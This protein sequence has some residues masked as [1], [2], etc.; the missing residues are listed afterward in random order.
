MKLAVFV[1]YFPPHM[2]SD[3]RIYQIS[4]GLIKEFNLFFAVF[5]PLRA[6]GNITDNSLKSY[7]ENRERIKLPENF[8]A[9]YLNLSNVLYRLWNRFELVAYFIT[10]AI[11]FVR[12]IGLLKSI[13]PNLVVVAH[14]SYHCGLIGTVVAKI[15]NIP[16]VLDYPDLWTSMTLETLSLQQNGLKSV[17]LEAIESIPIYLANHIIVVTNTIRDKVLRKGINKSK[18]TIIPNGVSIDEISVCSNFEK[19]TIEDSD[20]KMILFSGRLERWAGLDCLINAIPSVL[21]TVP[22]SLFVI[23]GDGSY[24][25]FLEGK[26]ASA[27]FQENVIFTGFLQREKIWNLINKAN[28]CISIFSEGDTGTAAI[29]IK[30]LEYMALGKPIVTTDCKGLNKFLKDKETVLLAKND[31]TALASA[32]TNLLQNPSLACSL[33][34]CAKKIVLESFDWRLLSND[35]AQVCH[36]VLSSNLNPN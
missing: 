2:G 11:L 15:L 16:I 31:P 35:F 21:S 23:A 28:I 32:I 17:V 34:S 19:E 3:Y 27:T 18:V 13:R 29:P 25:K 7:L 9:K 36:S 12:T 6:L 20:N 24:K 8:K 33:G 22:N 14:P 30:L 5:P 10:L 4:K 26:I 1:E